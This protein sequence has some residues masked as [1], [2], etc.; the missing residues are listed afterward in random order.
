M[1]ES[2]SRRADFIQEHAI[3]SEHEVTERKYA[4]N[5]EAV[6][7]SLAGYAHERR[8]PFRQVDRYFDVK[9]ALRRRGVVA[10]LREEGNAYA[11][12]FKGPQR[13]DGGRFE[14]EPLIPRWL[15]S[16]LTMLP[17]A[18]EVSKVRCEYVPIHAEATTIALDM[19]VG[20]GT[21]VEV[22][23][24]TSLHIDVWQERLGLTNQV[25]RSYR[26]L[27]RAARSAV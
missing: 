21:F 15:G 10:R 2:I 26:D 22:E 27:V 13:A 8:G 6:A 11:F 12:T 25:S 19:V 23:A 4:H 7:Q 1:Q 9:D 24:P 14:W 5:H 3:A 20:I 17:A 18:E 16:Q